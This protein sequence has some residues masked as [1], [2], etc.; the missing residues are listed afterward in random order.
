MLNIVY[1]SQSP[2][3][4]LIVPRA[5]D[6]DPST[7]PNPAWTT[8]CMRALMQNGGLAQGI[9]MC[10]LDNT[11]KLALFFYQQAHAEFDASIGH[12]S[13]AAPDQEKHG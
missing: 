1:A 13:N 6:F 7:F 4:Q 11:P 10:L 9:T 5:M 8:A 12:Q 2:S 3:P